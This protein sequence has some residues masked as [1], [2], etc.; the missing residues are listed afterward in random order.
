MRCIATGSVVASTTT[1][2]RTKRNARTATSHART[3]A[4]RV[5]G[6]A[7][8]GTG[9]TAS[10]AVEELVRL[11]VGGLLVEV[12]V[13]ADARLELLR[14]LVRRL[15]ALHAELELVRVRGAPE[16]LL[17]GDELAL[18]EVVDGLV[19]GL[20]P[21]LRA[22]RRDGLPYELRLLLVLDA[23]ADEVRRDHHLD[24]GHAA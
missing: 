20:H 4:R 3:G 10:A 7:T 21:V 17:V 19:E 16:R 1:R 6:L 24:G 12:G 11:R 2:T 22:A 8:T 5:P 14:L 15:D 13:V 18:E 23:V 9:L